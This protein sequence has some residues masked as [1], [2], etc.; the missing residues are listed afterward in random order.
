[1]PHSNE[2]STTL[3]R[4]G[5]GL[6]LSVLGSFR[7]Y[8][9]INFFYYRNLSQMHLKEVEKCLNCEYSIYFCYFFLGVQ[10]DGVAKFLFMNKD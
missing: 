1:M 9:L 8:F 6:S 10:F 5:S 7:L 2:T 4:P 3:S